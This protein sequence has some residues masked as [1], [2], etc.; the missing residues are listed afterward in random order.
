MFI[1]QK[2]HFHTHGEE[3]LDLQRTAAIRQK[4]LSYEENL[5]QSAIKL[6]Y[7]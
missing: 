4:V 3:N 7:F 6:S 5:R 2:V 1:D